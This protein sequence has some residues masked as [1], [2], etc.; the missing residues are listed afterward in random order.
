MHELGIVIHVVET[1]E[2]IVKEQKLTH[3]QSLVL[4]IGEASGVVPH[5]IEEVYP[6]AIEQSFLKDMKLEIEQIKA[7][8]LCECGHQYQITE[9]DGLCPKCHSQKFN[10]ISGRQFNIKQIVAY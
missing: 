5:Y 3:V 1:I 4:E 6:I 2:K 8:G 9:H 7:I 10:V